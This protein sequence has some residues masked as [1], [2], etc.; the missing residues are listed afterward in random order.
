MQQK[1]ADVRTRDVHPA[2]ALL[3]VLTR[4]CAWTASSSGVEQ[5]F[6]REEGSG[7]L[8]TPASEHTTEMRARFICFSGM[9]A[10]ERTRAVQRAREL[11]FAGWGP[12]RTTTKE[13]LHKG[14][15]RKRPGDLKHAPAT[16]A[17][18]LRNRRSSVNLAAKGMVPAVEPGDDHRPAGWHAGLE[19]EFQRQSD[20]QTSRKV[21]ALQ[22]GVHL[23]VCPHPYLLQ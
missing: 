8:R 11:W 17:S 23:Q 20:K 15:K 13:R 14:K 5:L 4:Y 19:K 7:V 1:Q 10:A 6:S 12:E 22:D 16:E 9:S 2:G 3:P 18:W 21:E